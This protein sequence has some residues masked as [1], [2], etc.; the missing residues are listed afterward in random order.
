MQKSL[1]DHLPTRPSTEKKQSSIEQKNR[2][3]TLETLEDQEKHLVTDHRIREESKG[4]LELAEESF[5][6]GRLIQREIE[7]GHHI[8][9]KNSEIDHRIREEREQIHLPL[10]GLPAMAGRL[11]QAKKSSDHRPR[12]WE[13]R[14]FEARKLMVLKRN[15][16]Q[17]KSSDQRNHSKNN[18][19]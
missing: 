1:P 16:D 18:N 9:K 14:I 13:K 2:Q 17:R 11:M 5:E 4:N 3:E 15:S 8:R 19:I 12:M 6:T 7:I 10:A